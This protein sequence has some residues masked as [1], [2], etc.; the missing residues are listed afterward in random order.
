MSDT[1]FRLLALDGG[2][3][4]GL[5]SAACLDHLEQHTGKRL[6][7]YFDLIVGTSTGA[8]IALGLSSGMSAAEVLRFYQEYGPHIFAGGRGWFGQLFRPKYDNRR[9]IEALKNTFGDQTMNDLK[10]PVC[11]AS[12]ELVQGIPR[13]FKDDHHPDLH[14]GGGLTVWKVAAA[15]S[16]APLVFPAVQ[17]QDQDSHIDGGIWANNPIMHGWPHRGWSLF[18]SAV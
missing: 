9:L 13:V 16:A 7:D 1:T 15:S 11:I 8:M 14:W 2:G 10:V 5:F 4:R 3:I 17:V 6:A 12:Y 18:R